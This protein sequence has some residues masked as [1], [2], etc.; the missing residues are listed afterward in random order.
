MKRRDFVTLLVGATTWLFAARAGQPGTLPP[1]RFRGSSMA[2][3]ASN[4][5][6][7]FVQRLRELGWIEGDTVAIEYRWAEGRKQRA[8]ELSSGGK[9]GNQQYSDRLRSAG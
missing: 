4:W 7:A 5:V 3:I 9:A 2:S 6:A 1:I 8:D